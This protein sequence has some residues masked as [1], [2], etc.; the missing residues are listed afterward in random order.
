MKIVK[1][2]QGKKLVFALVVRNCEVKTAKLDEGQVDLVLLTYCYKKGSFQ[3]F[4]LKGWP[5]IFI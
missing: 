2:T 4:Q 3:A 5:L 1:H